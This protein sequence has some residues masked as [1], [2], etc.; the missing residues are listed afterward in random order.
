MSAVHLADI[1]AAREDPS[2]VNMAAREREQSRTAN[3][4]GIAIR[5][6]HLAVSVQAATYLAVHYLARSAETVCL[7]RLSVALTALEKLSEPAILVVHQER[8]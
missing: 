6:R 3:I 1:P 7:I 8:G 2:H 5:I 4:S